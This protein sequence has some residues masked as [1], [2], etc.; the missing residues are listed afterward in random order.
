MLLERKT[1]ELGDGV[2]V[3]IDPEADYVVLRMGKES[4][5]IR[6]VEL[7]SM[8]Y[9]MADADTQ[10][11]LTPVRTTEVQ[12]FKRKHRIQLKKDMRRGEILTVTCNI[13]IPT[14]VVEG[15]KGIIED[16]KHSTVFNATSPVIIKP[17]PSAGDV[18]GAI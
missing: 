3:D 11:K 4:K 17:N 12:E 18:A 15:L 16:R 2:F 13:N 6:K 7:W 8:C 9:I 14:T 1:A 10:D 5:R